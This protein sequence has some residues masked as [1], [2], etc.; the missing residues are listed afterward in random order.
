MRSALAPQIFPD[1]GQDTVARHEA[2]GIWAGEEARRVSSLEPKCCHM[3]T[4]AWITA[5]SL[6]CMMTACLLCRSLKASGLSRQLKL[7]VRTSYEPLQY[8]GWKSE[9]TSLLLDLTL[10]CLC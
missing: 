1:F 7:V 10:M 3:Q 4:L 2:C 6:A 8:K 5:E 9:V